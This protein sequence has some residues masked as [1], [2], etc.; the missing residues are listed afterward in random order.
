MEEDLFVPCTLLRDLMHAA[1][2]ES[3]LI[4][5]ADY[6][7]RFEEVELRA[8]TG[9]GNTGDVWV[10]VEV[11]KENTSEEAVAVEGAV[12]VAGS[13]RKRWIV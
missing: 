7:D 10:D 5:Y 3:L 13:K 12:T 4:R 2:D 8:G 6:R 9:Y 1:N 11:E